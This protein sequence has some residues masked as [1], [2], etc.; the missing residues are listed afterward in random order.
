MINKKSFQNGYLAIK[1]C[2]HGYFAYNTNDRFVGKSLDQYGE[3]TEQEIKA[4]TPLLRPGDLVID[5]GAYI[6]TH[7]I[8]FAKLVSP[9]GRVIAIEAQRTAIAFLQTNIALNNLMNV[10]CINKFIT[11]KEGVIKS[12]ILDQRIEQ[13]FGSLSIK[14]MKGGEIIKA[15]TI[16]KINLPKNKS[17]KLIKIDVEEQEAKV[18][19]GAKKTIKKYRPFLYVECSSKKESKKIIRKLLKY[20]YVPYWHF[21]H[22]FNE[23]NFFKNK[24]NV[25]K[26]YVPEVNLICFPKEVKV[27][28]DIFEKVMGENDT[29]RKAYRRQLNKAKK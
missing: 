28:Q 8:P 13:N 15:T 20:N 10:I 18:L 3:W 11:N 17:L 5:V 29:W 23:N 21:F 6:G 14:N 25:F 26:G 9:G 7:T 24:K 1:K 2:R 4:L 19:A 12:L 27:V 22:Y 16:D